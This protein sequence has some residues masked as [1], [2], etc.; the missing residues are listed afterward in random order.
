MT[1]KPRSQHNLRVSNG[2]GTCCVADIYLPEPG[3]FPA[4]AVITRTMYGRSR[5]RSEGLGWA[6]NGFAYVVADVRGRYDSDGTF[7][8]Y[9]SERDDGAALVDFVCGQPWANGGVVAYGG[10]YS[11]YTAWAMA[12]ERPIAVRAVVSLC[13][14]MELARTKFDPSGILRLYE[15]LGWWLQHGDARVSRTDMPG[16]ALPDLES[17][18]ALPVKQLPDT[19][20]VHLPTWGGVLDRGPDHLDDQRITDNELAELTVPSFHV[21][22]WYDLVTETSV[23]HFDLVGSNVEPRPARRLM[24]GPWTHE[25]FVDPSGRH[26][27]VASIEWGKICVQWLHSV[28]GHRAAESKSASVSIFHRGV[29]TWIDNETREEPE[30]SILLYAHNRRRLETAPQSGSAALSFEY[31][32]ADPYP[33]IPT[34]HDRSAVVRS[35]FVAFTTRPLAADLHIDGIPEAHLT[36]STTA[37]EADWIVRLLHRSAGGSL[38]QIGY[39]VAVTGASADAVRVPL[40]R[41][42]VHLERGSELIL[43]ITGSDFPA[44]TRNLNS[45]NRYT[46]TTIEKATQT[47][48]VGAARTLVR[49][50]IRQEKQ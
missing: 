16:N 3:C 41:T 12:V 38:H 14:S 9:H 46:G 7:T 43:H 28:L 20:G 42:A 18:L 24:I 35:D 19:T 23:A 44:L 32:P 13:P 5:H 27:P 29:D 39:G 1:N 8:P 11:A 36:A 15:H 10:S 48:H 47:V 22:G 17:Y 40:S 30:S 49:L 25:L 26:G 31:N 37:P 21:G 34:H 50:P 2:D 45:G 6:R 4:T 33:T